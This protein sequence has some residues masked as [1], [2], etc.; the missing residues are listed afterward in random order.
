MF[1]NKQVSAE[2][3]YIRGPILHFLDDPSTSESSKKSYQYFDDGMLIV[4][5]KKIVQ[6]GDFNQIKKTVP[7]KTKII[8]YQNGLILPG[9]ID[10]HIHYPQLD[11]IAANSGGQLLQ[12]LDKYTFPFERK[13]KDPAYS[14]D[15]AHFFSR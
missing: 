4:K 5:D 2:E 12:W 9:F 10:T 8:R 14:T 6:M 11:M 13:F 1:F 3:L 7:P 15:V